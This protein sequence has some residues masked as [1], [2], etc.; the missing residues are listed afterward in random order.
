MHIWKNAELQGCI[1]MNDEVKGN[2]RVHVFGRVSV[3]SYSKL[4]ALVRFCTH[5]IL[6]LLLARA[7]RAIYRN[8]GLFSTQL[9]CYFNAKLFYSAQKHL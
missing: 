4:K 3:L 9:T 8:T 5:R 1:C 2:R 6:F 7:L